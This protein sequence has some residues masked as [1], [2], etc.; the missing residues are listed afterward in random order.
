MPKHPKPREITDKELVARVQQERSYADSQSES[1]LSDQRINSNYA[2]VNNDTT[3][4]IPTTGMSGTRFFFTAS[5]VNTLV[6]HLSKTFCSNQK[7][8]EFTPTGQSPEAL[9]AA[10]QLEMM[11]NKVLYKD[12]P[13]FEIISELL[14][15]SA[16][17]KNGIAKITWREKPEAF[18][19]MHKGVSPEAIQQLIAIREE[20]GF[21][22]EIVSEEVTIEAEQVTQIDPL[23]GE[24]LIISETEAEGDY[25]LRLTRKKEC[26]GIDVLPPEEFMIN[27]DTT[28]INNDGLT[29]FI[30]HR[31]EMPRTDAQA[32]FPDADE[33]DFGN[34]DSTTYEYEKAARHAVDGTYI[35]Y[36]ENTSTSAETNLVEVTE[37]WIRADR[38]R[39]G[40]AEWRHGFIS[41]S[42][43]LM[44]E[45]WYGP[46]PF[47][48]YSYFPVPHKFYGLSVWDRVRT[49]DETATGTGRAAVDND[50]LANTT[51]MITKQGMID[52]R[53]LQSGKPGVI[54]ASNQFK[55]EDIMV[56]PH[57]SGSGMFTSIFDELRRQ[58][59]GDIGIDPISGQVSTDIE[60]S[61]N[62][63]A[64][65]AMAIDNASVK[66]EGM[67]RRFAEMPLKDIVWMIV[68][69]LVRNKD[70]D[71][72]KRLTG[73]QPFLAG[74]LGLH[75]IME[76]NDLTSKVGLGFQTS[77][78]KIAA[79]QTIQSMLQQLEANPTPATYNLIHETLK[80]FA[81]ENPA[82]IIGHLDFWI[83]K[84]ARMQ[85]Q[86]QEA[87][88]IQKQTADAQ[89]AQV[90]SELQQV[91]FEQELEKQKQD[92][93]QRVEWE[94]AQAE[95]RAK[96]AE[97]EK[98]LAEARKI[99][100]ETAAVQNVNPQD[101]SVSL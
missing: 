53:Q 98:K 7:V 49:Y 14:R 34:F 81:Y 16:I 60:K 58:V 9:A 47:T 74:Q 25:T 22:V 66:I 52:R 42:N 35:A 57:N 59:I 41:A 79:A 45:E 31:R 61:G 70:S 2:F 10:K 39:D 26:I 33:S 28:S 85:Q 3:Y 91:Q 63:A 86:E 8:V 32:M 97:T 11:V 65:T 5:V 62:D 73:G 84:A 12:N 6:M 36:G 90:Q 101:V 93:N 44:D 48:S 46:L 50:R 20:E 96:D 75:N 19:E 18:E 43:L 69:E 37:F 78:Q 88:M 99:D 54:D 23:T 15:S 89:T 72:V 100:A 82:Q 92:F 24:E 83:E 27:E 67:T 55:P 94:K 56:V 80:G 71:Y 77:Q 1:Y 30:A 64:K 87:L 13:G 38:N 29:R 68:M 95:V 40:F 4:T 17:N 21:E 76:K 51:R